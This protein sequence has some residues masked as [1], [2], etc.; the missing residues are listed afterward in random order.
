MSFDKPRLIALPWDSHFFNRDVYKLSLNGGV[1]RPEFLI[2][3]KSGSLVYVFSDT[4]VSGLSEPVDLKLTLQCEVNAQHVFE[5]SGAECEIYSQQESLR[6]EFYELAVASSIMSRFRVDS[7]LASS[8]AD[9]MYKTWI[10]NA[11]NDPIGHRV[12]FLRDGHDVAGMISIKFLSS[13]AS[14]E[15][16]AVADKFQGKG[17]GRDLMSRSMRLFQEMNI[18][19]VSVVTQA[20]NEAACRLYQKF[21][22]VT[23]DLTYVYHV[24]V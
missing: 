14:I 17:Y 11:I 21:G 6:S 1:F 24:H 13:H 4:A 8:K 7:K 19:S 5:G 12:V 20:K 15:L 18:K 23:K 2:E 16:V 3:A 9:D 10:D 22:F